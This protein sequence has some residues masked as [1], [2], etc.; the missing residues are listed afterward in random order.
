MF[1][2]VGLCWLLFA[3][4]DISG[5]GSRVEPPAAAS[6]AAAT[7]PVPVPEPSEAA[8]SYHRYDD[9]YWAFGVVWG[10]LIPALFLFTGLSARI[11]NL[12][13]SLGRKRF[14]VIGLYF[15]IFAIINFAIDLPLNYYHGYF[16]EHAYGL[17]NQAF[18]HWLGDQFK[19]LLLGLGAGVLLLWVPYLLLRRSPRRWWF[20]TGLLAVPVILLAVL[21][22]P[23][24]ID[25]LFNKFGPMKD[26]TLEVAILQLA[27]RAGIEGGRVF[28]V[29]KSQDTKTL[30]AYV[31]GFG[32]TKRIVLWDTT[33]AKLDRP[34][35]YFVMGHEIGHYVL[36]HIWKSIAFFSVLIMAMLYAVHLTAGWVIRRSRH[37]FGFDRLDDIASLPLIILL[38][39]LY[40]L[41]VTPIALAYSRHNEHEADR[42]G[43]ELTKDNR[44]AA[45]AFVRLQTE[46]LSLPRRGWL[47]K[48]WRASH[49]TLGERID[50][51][52]AYRPW[53]RNEPLVYDSL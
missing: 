9:L 48:L 39:S 27:D 37:R 33:I 22:I 12:A 23:V 29:D 34:E 24:W 42:F 47:H 20:Y 3:G 31:T 32:N 6:A 30:N 43:L 14:F 19:G 4:A 25:P 2:I 8:L 1:L 21:I 50:F 44:A 16:R 28:E 41:I 35:L 45:N 10:L 38:L 53:E 52:N 49:P 7:D 17:S 18:G 46:N 36:G 11:R 51:S 26:K 15:I 13:Q 40:L 5:P